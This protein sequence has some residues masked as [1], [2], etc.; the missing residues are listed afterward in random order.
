MIEPLWRV[1]CPFLS[2]SSTHTPYYTAISFMAIYCEEIK[3]SHMFTKRF[4]Q[5][6]SLAALFTMAKL[7]KE[8]NVHQD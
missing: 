6:Y 5:I 7:R 4:L 8:P 2:K 1:I 3:I